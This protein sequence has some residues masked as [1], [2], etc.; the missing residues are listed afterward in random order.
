[1]DILVI[2]RVSMSFIYGTLL[3]KLDSISAYMSSICMQVSMISDSGWSHEHFF[4][5]HSAEKLSGHPQ[6]EIKEL[7]A[8]KTCYF[9]LD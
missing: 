2:G 4:K 6:R 3:V 7:V 1:M 5:S 9:N 8:I